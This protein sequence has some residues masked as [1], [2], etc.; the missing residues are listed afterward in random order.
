MRMVEPVTFDLPNLLSG[1]S[2][3]RRCLVGRR[4]KYKE[5]GA[6]FR[7]LFAHGIQAG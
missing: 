6:T 3:L 7:R 4:I 2:N 1:D 5:P